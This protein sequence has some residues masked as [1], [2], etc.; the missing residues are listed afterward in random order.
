MIGR[1]YHRD[2]LVN[3]KQPVYVEKD[4]KEL[5]LLC[6]PETLVVTGFID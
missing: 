1:T 6:D 2:D 4:G 3:G 5:K